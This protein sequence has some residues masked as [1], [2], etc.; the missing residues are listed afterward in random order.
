M[1][2]TRLAEP[3]FGPYRLRIDGGEGGEGDD[4]G[5]GGGAGGDAGG[6]DWST[7]IAGLPQELRDSVPDLTTSRDFPAFVT[8]YREQGKLLGTKRTA[9]PDKNAPMSQWYDFFKTL[10]RPDKPEEYDLGSDFGAPEGLPWDEQ[11]LPELLD[12][13]H[14]AGLNNDQVRAIAKGYVEASQRHFER[15]GAA[16]LQSYEDEERALQRE[17]GDKYDANL[18][19]AHRA[20]NQMAGDDFDSIEQTRLMDGRLVGDH[21]VLVRI[22][23]KAGQLMHEHGLLAESGAGQAS[24]RGNDPAAIRAKIA[25]LEADPRMADQS[26]P[27]HKLVLKEWDALTRELGDEPLNPEEGDFFG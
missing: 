26:H 17:W 14:R 7:M 3:T 8:Q 19:L 4:G 12:V 27:E 24:G 11:S 2:R 22:I 9:I 5:Q 15:L 25:K 6:S 10:G 13:M 1:K 23:A 16:A 20:W 18:D 21:P